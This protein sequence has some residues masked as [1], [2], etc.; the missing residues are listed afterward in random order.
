[1]RV[2]RHRFGQQLCM[3]EELVTRR[4]HLH[5]QARHPNVVRV[6]DA[7]EVEVE[8]GALA[9]GRRPPRAME[10]ASSFAAS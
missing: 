1:M 3:L 2:G 7:I 9:H 6:Q 8:E 10:S 4:A 5:T